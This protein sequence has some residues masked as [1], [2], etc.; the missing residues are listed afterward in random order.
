[1]EEWQLKEGKLNYR[2]ALGR[3]LGVLKTGLILDAGTGAMAK[4]LVNGLSLSVMSV[5]LNKRVFPHV[6]KKVGQ[7]AFFLSAR[8][9][10]TVIP[11]I[12]ILHVLL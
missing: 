1:M 9:S 11:H 2:E 4:T 12:L 10:R 8:V 6:S 7:R 3:R 5:D